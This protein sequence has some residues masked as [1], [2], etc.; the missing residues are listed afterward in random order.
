M[1]EDGI[2]GAVLSALAMKRAVDHLTDVAMPMALR[3]SVGGDLVRFTFTDSEVGWW[4]TTRC[5]GTA[6]PDSPLDS[7]AATTVPRLVFRE[8]LELA[9]LDP[10]G[11]CTVVVHHEESVHIAGTAIAASESRPTIPEPPSVAALSCVEHDF[12]LPVG[13]L[14]ADDEASFVAGGAPLKV[15]GEMLERFKRR[16]VDHVAVYLTD[17]GALLVGETDEADADD[18]LVLMV[19]AHSDP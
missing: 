13:I 12:A 17:D 6:L 11:Q 3:L 2:A 8:A 4:A 15:G 19:V 16:H 9:Q 1:P 5:R 7:T 14:D 10:S 18:R